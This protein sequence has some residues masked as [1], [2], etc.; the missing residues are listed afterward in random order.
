MALEGFPG[1][2]PKV[3]GPSRCTDHAGNTPVSIAV[4]PTGGYTRQGRKGPSHRSF[5]PS[6]R[7]RLHRAFSAPASQHGRH[8]D[9]YQI[10]LDRVGRQASFALS[11]HGGSPRVSRRYP[12]SVCLPGFLSTARTNRMPD[13]ISP[14][15][16]LPCHMP[17]TSLPVHPPD[18]PVMTSPAVDK[19]PLRPCRL[20]S[21]PTRPYASSCLGVPRSALRCLGLSRC[22]AAWVQPPPPSCMTM[23]ASR[24]LWV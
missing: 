18:A 23:G 16:L 24:L 1:G 11:E 7:P 21:F 12:L 4:G 5:W 13:F 3:R 17:C 14:V 19:F 8:A 9:G 15:C 20:R 2:G 10:Q 22:L 6:P